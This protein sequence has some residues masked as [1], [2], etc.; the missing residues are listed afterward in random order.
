MGS[1]VE[2]SFLNHES[3]LKY[4]IKNEQIH[5]P[6]NTDWLELKFKK[7]N[8]EVQVFLNNK[9][10]GTTKAETLFGDKFGFIVTGLG[11]NVQVEIEDYWI[12]E[13]RTK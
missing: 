12:R 4:L 13:I 11:E 7:I 5:E 1:N 10:M 3:E 9:L 8:Q 6:N 2:F